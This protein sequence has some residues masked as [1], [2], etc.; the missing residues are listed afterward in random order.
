MARKLLSLWTILS[1]LAVVVSLVGTAGMAQAARPEEPPGQAQAS[2]PN[3][4]LEEIVDRDGNRIFDNLEKRMAGA[5]DDHS[6]AVIVL[7]DRPPLPADEEGLRRQIGPFDVKH[8]L[9]NVNGIVTT[10]NK[11]QIIAASRVSFVK[12]VEFD[13]PIVATMDTARSWSGVEAAVSQL[14]VS[15]SRDNSESGY[16]AADVAVAIIDTGIDA[17]HQALD[18]GK[19]LAFQ[20]YVGPTL[21]VPPY[22][23]H[24]HG[25]HVASMVAGTGEGSTNLRYR[26]VAPGAALLGAKVLDAAGSGDT[27]NAV[28]ALDWLKTYKAANNIPVL[29]A[30]MSFGVAGSANG[31]DSLS[32]AINDAAAA[33]IISVVAA[34]N[35]GAWARTIGSPGAAA[36]AITVGAM[37]DVG[38]GGFHLAGFSSRGPTADGRI[39]PDISAPGVNIT[40][41][42]RGTATG[43]VAYSGTSMATPFTAGV[44]ALMLDR[45]PNLTTEQV[46]AIFQQTAIDWGP[47][48]KDSESGFGRLDALAAVNAAGTAQAVSGPVVPAH[49]YLPGNALASGAERRH[50]LYEVTAG[51]RLAVALT[52]PD[53][54]CMSFFR[55]GE[56]CW[57]YPTY[58]YD[59]DLIDPAGRTVYSTMSNGRQD[60]ASVVAS[61]AGTYTA[62]VYACSTCNAGGT[63]Y[64]DVSGATASP[65]ST[66]QPPTAVGDSYGTDEDTP[67]VVAAPGLL[68]NDSDD[69]SAP[70]TAS[71]VS[72]PGHGTLTLNANG[73]F[74]YTPSANYSGTDSFTYTASDGT[75]PSN[76]ATVS[77][78]IAPTPDAP[79]ADAKSVVAPSG[80]A[81]NVNLTG[82]DADGCTGTYSFAVAA[83]PSHGSVGPSTGPMACTGSGS[84][85]VAVSYSPTPGYSGPDGFAFTISDGTMTSN[86]A[87]VSITVSQ[88]S[89]VTVTGI[90]PAMGKRGQKL[91]VQVS[92]S[93]FKPGAR[94]SLGSGITVS[95]IVVDQT[96]TSLTARLSIGAKA[97][98][99][100]RNVV[101]TNLDAT[102]GTL[103]GGFNVLSR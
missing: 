30:N 57:W 7:F 72:G 25:T 75:S 5:S 55:F 29:V 20:D 43:Y 79:T 51:A 82:L 24:G 10:L 68:A 45:N 62:R 88:S 83:G 34:G 27:N 46:K 89:S 93:G 33:G 26:G 76:L 32:L 70:L 36:G 80:Q 66:N 81:I 49:D 101:V 44:V 86:Q 94:L 1:L 85:S 98:L 73:S 14:G 15:G 13:A 48:G 56:E 102:S 18:G 92:G 96:G 63:Y 90:A 52:L 35:E 91:N 103:Q 39:K 6:F 69:G 42:Q 11:G 38:E 40:A 61:V 99:G 16:S 54:D 31:T 19:V 58:D 21:T 23:D 12:Q 65:P 87:T 71:R 53:T 9:G 3:P 78:D 8:R 41:A 77:I 60:T 28:R 84:L 95:N 4:E 74:T 22:D 17:N 59:L 47:Q 67:L 97:A 2:Q 64:L 50:S 37:A 100:L